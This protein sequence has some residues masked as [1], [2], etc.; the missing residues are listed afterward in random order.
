MAAA[1]QSAHDQASSGDDVEP[2]SPA[3]MEEERKQAAQQ[4]LLTISEIDVIGR[5]I[6][7]KKSVPAAK[8]QA[9][10]GTAFLA[11][12]TMPTSA[13]HTWASQKGLPSLVKEVFHIPEEK[14]LA[15]EPML[16]DPPSYNSETGKRENAPQ[17]LTD[18]R[19]DCPFLDSLPDKKERAQLLLATIVRCIG[20]ERYDARMRSLVK[21]LAM[22]LGLPDI[23]VGQAEDALI[24]RITSAVLSQKSDKKESSG[25]WWKVGLAS[26]V[27]GGLLV[28]TGGLA[29]PALIAGMGAMGGAIG[30]GVAAATGA[31]VAFFSSA[32]GGA[33]LLSIFGAGGST[34][35][36]KK[37]AR[38]THGLEVF[39]FKRLSADP[40]DL[41]GDVSKA[42]A[43]SAQKAQEKKKDS[44]QGKSWF[45]KMVP[46]KIWG[47]DEKGSSAQKTS[48]QEGDGS[49][50][51][52]TKAA[53]SAA[54]MH[55]FIC[56]TGLL[57]G[58]DTED[59]ERVWGGKGNSSPDVIN[60][61]SSSI[62]STLGMDESGSTKK[63]G[64]YAAGAK[65][66][67]LTR[68]E[69][70]AQEDE[71]DD[72]EDVPDTVPEI[73]SSRGWFRR[74][75]PYGEIYSLKWEPEV[76]QQLGDDVSR[77]VHKF[78]VGKMK[79]QILK[80]TVINT[81]MAAWQLPSKA[82]D[83]LGFIDST[84]SMAIDRAEKAGAALADT[85]EEKAQGNRPVTLIGYSMGAR[86]IFEC[87]EELWRRAHEKEG[88]TEAASDYIH[89]VVYDVIL[90]GAPVSAAPERWM[91]VREIVAGRLVNCYCVNDFVLRYMYRA[92]NLA[93]HVA[94]VGPVGVTDNPEL[95]E[96]AARGEELEVQDNIATDENSKESTTT[97]HGASSSAADATVEL[98]VCEEAGSSYPANE[99]QNTT[100]S[101]KAPQ[102][103]T[104]NRA[105]SSTGGHAAAAASTDDDG[106]YFSAHAVVE[107]VRS[108]QKYVNKRFEAVTSKTT[109]VSG[110]LLENKKAKQAP[111]STTWFR[112]VENIN[113]SSIVNGHIDYR[114]KLEE[115][116]RK[117]RLDYQT[118]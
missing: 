79:K 39:T 118:Y 94:G 36:G 92:S 63:N 104:A 71:D 117:I 62:S 103:E 42:A 74:M 30:G 31:S 77:F 69:D 75:I 5:H 96:A 25:R 33:L 98:P 7:F 21:R 2:L 114:A 85:L 43:E 40:R 53:T 29:A 44:S 48:E 32:G 16:G 88:A 65:E 72:A 6:D 83:L 59:Y 106:S 8:K 26:I 115:V 24:M 61:A 57:L 11:A 95:A 19:K 47:K 99:H 110:S 86:V 64:E 73:K 76:L 46:D 38:R 45:K 4:I 23:A 67:T 10:A 116:M 81:L 27:G 50:D 13:L 15:L 9:L 35:A 102:T 109:E 66:S 78:F 60:Q 111:V 52:A 105:K 49:E 58:D 37:M 14:Y 54:G 97:T 87:L 90:L 100:G 1:E 18:L 82:I 108:G 55:V 41:H 68:E 93:W 56:I 22:I 89:S 80:Y 20:E 70:K 101:E 84:W 51:E 28:V 3:A 112:G 34:L 113:V 12:A 17:T 107:N 91:R